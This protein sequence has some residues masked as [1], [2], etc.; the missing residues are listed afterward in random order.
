MLDIKIEEKLFFFSQKRALKGCADSSL[1]EERP[2]TKRMLLNDSFCTAEIK[3]ITLEQVP[4][5]LPPGA[6]H[7]FDF[8]LAWVSVKPK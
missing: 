4:P 5:A 2:W 3:N 6:W 8:E 1:I 7:D